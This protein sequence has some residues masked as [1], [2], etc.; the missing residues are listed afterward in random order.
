MT[1]GKAIQILRDL[2]ERGFSV[3]IIHGRCPCAVHNNEVGWSVLVFDGNHVPIMG[4]Q[5]AARSFEHCVEIAQ[6]EATEFLGRM[7]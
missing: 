1:H 5:E 6:K 3:S 2:A 7:N 4:C